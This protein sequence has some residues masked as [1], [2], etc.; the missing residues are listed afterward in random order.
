MKE[1]YLPYIKLPKSFTRLLKT[2]FKGINTVTENRPI[3]EAMNDDKGFGFIVNNCLREYSQNKSIESALSMAGWKFLRERLASVYFHFL[4]KQKFD[5]DVEIEAIDDLLE[6]EEIFI[7]STF[8]SLSRLFMLGFYLKVVDVKYN[9]LDGMADQ[10]Q[11][12]LNDSLAMKDIIFAGSVKHERA[13]YVVLGCFLL[14]SYMDEKDIVKFFSNNKM[15][16]DKV[17]SFLS[18]QQQAN[19]LNNLLNY[20][21]SI[22]DYDMF[23]YEKV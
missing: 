11:G 1:L 8:D 9:G 3:M 12:I 18:P 14:R 6:F 15:S 19:I 20:S 2:H 23:Y 7:D 4:C 17:L 22:E 13:D 21:M 5:W 10:G 16:Y